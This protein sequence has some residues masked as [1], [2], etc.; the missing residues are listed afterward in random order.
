MV[1]A[2][3]TKLQYFWSPDVELVE[4]LATAYDSYSEDWTS[5]LGPEGECWLGHSSTDLA[6]QS[7]YDPYWT[8]NPLGVSTHFYMKGAE[9]VGHDPVWSHSA[10]KRC[11]RE[12]VQTGATDHITKRLILVFI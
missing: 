8:T 6:I 9:M 5:L 1:T 7:L 3:A 10:E 4:A 11:F 2:F 12:S